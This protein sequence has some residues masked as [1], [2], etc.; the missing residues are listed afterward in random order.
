MSGGVG[1]LRI[2]PWEKT[3]DPNGAKTIKIANPPTI[4]FFMGFSSYLY[5]TPNPKAVK[6]PE[7]V[8]HLANYPVIGKIIFEILPP[9]R[10][11]IC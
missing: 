11:G 8:S 3:G 1:P 4:A 9:R 6:P 10:M 2:P 5:Y 7:P